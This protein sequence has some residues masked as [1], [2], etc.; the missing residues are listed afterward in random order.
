MGEPTEGQLALALSAR[1]TFL[2]D[3]DVP[4]S[5][6]RFLAARGHDVT[7]AVDRL[8]PK[9]PDELVATLGDELQSV[10]ITCNARDFKK[11]AWRRPPTGHDR[12]RHL[13]LLT[14]LGDK[15]H[16]PDRITQVVESIEFEFRF[17]QGQADRRLFIEVSDHKFTVVR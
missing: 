7:F 15:S 1:I 14:L 13:G 6:G 8:G 5:V 9:S 12:F 17:C 10:L 2:I 3:E 11:L 4:Q 16:I